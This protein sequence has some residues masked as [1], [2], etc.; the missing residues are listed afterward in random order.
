MGAA[1]LWPQC[2]QSLPGGSLSQLR[3]QAQSCLPQTSCL[4]LGDC[5][6]PFLIVDTWH[7][8]WHLQF[9]GGSCPSQRFPEI[10]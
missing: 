3:V 7:R 8:V 10:R 6:S 9:S 5:A 1:C 2:D 4:Y